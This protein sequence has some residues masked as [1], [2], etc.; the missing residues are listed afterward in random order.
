[1]RSI[2]LPF[3]LSR[4]LILAVFICARSTIFIQ[5]PATVIQNLNPELRLSFAKITESLAQVLL[6]G[7]V[8]WY[9]SIVANGYADP[10]FDSAV[11]QSWCFFPVWAGVLWGFNALTS[12][13][14]LL[15][16][17]FA[18]LLFYFS[19]CF[20]IKIC[21]NDRYP[22]SVSSS[23]VW[24]LCFFPTSYFF[25]VPM[26]ESIFLFLT[27]GSI[28]LLSKKRTILSAALFT[29]S[30]ATRPT[31]LLLLPAYWMGVFGCKD[32]DRRLK[33]IAAILAPLGLVAFM[34]YLWLHLGEPLAFIRGQK[35]WERGNQGL[36][37]LFLEIA[38][39]P[40]LIFKPWNF[41]W[42]NIGT[43]LLCFAASF[44]W[45]TKR[46]YDYL[47]YCLV[48]SVSILLTGTILSAARFTLLL[49]PVFIALGIWSKTR[50][51]ELSLLALF[52][53]LLAIMC[54]L[55]ARG[56]NLAMT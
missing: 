36:I 24:L 20:I 37:G 43:T 32:I 31:G 46:R 9:L 30:T 15:G 56:G 16:F 6:Q 38:R 26:T 47:L 49:F 23:A 22:Q 39:D 14:L 29:L 5:D 11:Q 52:A 33:W 28:L 27:T 21:E 17:L 2:I 41:I 8:N 50:E 3:L 7:D 35:A 18:N 54:A 40:F 34:I 51:R 1:M 19:L 10:P 44:Y 25:S 55:Y 53:T 48:P 12:S 45:W 13:P 4:A 42:L